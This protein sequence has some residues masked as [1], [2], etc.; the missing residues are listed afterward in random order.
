MRTERVD[1]ARCWWC[2]DSRQSVAHLMLK[3]RKWRRERERMLHALEAK[4]I[5]ISTRRNEQDVLV[6]FGE[7]A[8][9]AVLRFI[10]CTAV[11]KR[12]EADSTQGLDEWDVG[13][14]DR[15]GTDD[16]RTL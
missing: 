9:E 1:D 6:L 7:T 12:A 16:E 2:N 4:K 14:L 8:V 5:K 11:G 10:E 13:L 15:E 3:C